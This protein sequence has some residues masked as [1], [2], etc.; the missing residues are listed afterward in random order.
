MSAAEKLFEF[1]PGSDLT[2]WQVVDDSVMGG[3]SVGQFTLN[4][5]GHAVFHGEVSLDNNGGFTSVRYR[6]A[7]PIPI[8][9]ADRFILH[10]RGDGKR[11]KFRIKARQEDYAYYINEFSTSG[12]WQTIELP[13][14][15]MYAN[16]RGRRLDLPNYAGDTLAE[17]AFLIANKRAEAFRLEIDWMGLGTIE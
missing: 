6:F 3:R 8:T 16:F 2:G 9:T 14:A 5:A 15:G 1:T 11:F 17:V 10:L 4:E 12:D 7:D 13:M